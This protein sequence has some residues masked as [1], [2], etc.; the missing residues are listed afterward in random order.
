[1]YL[2]VYAQH[3]KGLIDVYVHALNILKSMFELHLLCSEKSV[4]IL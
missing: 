3:T 2:H 1:M 4:E